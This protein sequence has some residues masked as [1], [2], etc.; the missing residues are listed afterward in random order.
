MEGHEGA[1]SPD[2]VAAP[3]AGLGAPWWIVGGWAI[4]AFTGEPRPHEDVD[5]AFFRADRPR[6]LDHLA[7]DH[8]IWSNVSGTLRP[9]RRPD[10][11]PPDCPQRWVRRD[12]GS[13]WLLDLL[14]TPHDGPTWISG[15][16]GRLRLPLDDATFIGRD[17]IRYLRPEYLRPELVLH[18]K[19]RHRRTRD[20][21]D[22][23]RAVPRLEPERRDWLRGALELIHPGHPWIE[24]LGHGAGPL[25]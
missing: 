24:R 10:E 19:A 6:L 11:L 3:L 25:S 15:R 1:A 4:D 20:D 14:M 9:L 17:G 7:P 2:R 12:A 16:D 13:P 21:R 22:F 23:A 18:M 5:V 8:C